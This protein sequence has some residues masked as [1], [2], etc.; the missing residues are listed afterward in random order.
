MTYEVRVG[1]SICESR[2]RTNNNATTCQSSATKG[3]AIRQ[4]LAGRW[5]NTIVLISPMRRAN[6]TA[7]R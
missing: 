5:V 3:T 4:R 7:T 6:G 1:T 2:L